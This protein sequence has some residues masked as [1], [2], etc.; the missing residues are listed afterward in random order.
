MVG[1][2]LLP[3]I[4]YSVTWWNSLHQGQTIRMFLQSVE[5]KDGNLIAHLSLWQFTTSVLLFGLALLAAI[6]M[7]GALLLCPEWGI[8]LVALGSIS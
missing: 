4:H 6:G 5:V 1:I 2:V 7:A 8:A 3:V